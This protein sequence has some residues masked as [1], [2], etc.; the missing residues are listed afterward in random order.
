MTEEPSLDALPEQF[1]LLSE[2]DQT[3]YRELRSIVGSRDTR[4][5]RFRRLDT[6]SESLS[7]I[8]SFC[9]RGDAGDSLRCLVCGICWLSTTDVAI[10]IRHLRLLLNKSKSTI[11]G[12]LLK[13][14]YSPVPLKSE[15]G[16]RL[17][18]LIPQLK[19]HYLD[20]RLWSIRRILRNDPKPRA[21][22]E[23]PIIQK[24]AEPSN[25]NEKSVFDYFPDFDSDFF[26]FAKD[27]KMEQLGF[28][29][30]L[31]NSLGL[32]PGAYLSKLAANWAREHRGQ[33]PK[34][35]RKLLI[36]K[37]KRDVVTAERKKELLMPFDDGNDDG[38]RNCARF[39]C[40]RWQFEKIRRRLGIEKRKRGIPIREDP[41]LDEVIVMV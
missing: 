2:A 8:R 18:T 3:R 36:R 6:L 23:V 24:A 15:E 40:G 35:L 32:L 11:N 1:S 9:I 14:G 30:F 4:Y 27:D 7:R 10:N 41:F 29:G 26:V 38:V 22:L 34:L 28:A 31:L 20:L 19:D 25:T 37:S 17:M 16:E 39:C 13:M 12:A 33:L 21:P 5:N